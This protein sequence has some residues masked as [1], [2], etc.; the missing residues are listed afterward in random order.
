MA[1]GV[2]DIDVG[3]AEAAEGLVEGCEKVFA[4]AAVAV[5]AVP[6]LVAGFGG[7]DEFVAVAGEV[8]GEDASD[9]F[10]GG[11]GWRAVVI[12]EVEVGDAAVEGTADHFAGFLVVVD[13]A[14]VVPAAE[15]DGGEEEAGVSA[16]AVWDGGHFGA[17]RWVGRIFFQEDLRAWRRWRSGGCE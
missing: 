6:H 1:V 17:G 11:A 3:D 15:G 10:F 12:G 8:F 16:A 5:G 2:K 13:V 7:D 4:G 14:E 9:V